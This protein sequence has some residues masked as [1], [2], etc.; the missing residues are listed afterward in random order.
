MLMFQSKKT[1]T[2]FVAIGDVKD[3]RDAGAEIEALGVRLDAARERAAKAS[4]PWAKDFWTTTHNRLFNQWQL[5]IQLKDTG[6]RQKGVQGKTKINYDWW[7][8]SE[9][10]K[11][12][13][14]PFLDNMFDN[15]GL[16]KRLDE[17]WAKSKE[18]KLEKARLGLA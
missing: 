14:I 13:S 5:M 11:M 16:D 15:A 18:Q 9:E 1:N 4:T 8:R 2:E 12:I 6:L 3:W 10:I 17:S 7:E